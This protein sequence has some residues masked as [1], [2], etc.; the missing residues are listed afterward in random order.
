MKKKRWNNSRESKEKV[1]H[2][3]GTNSNEEQDD[4]VLYNIHS[5]VDQPIYVDAVDGN[6][7]QFQLDTGSSVS[8]M[9]C[10]DFTAVFGDS[11]PTLHPTNRRLGSYSGHKIEI[12][13][14]EQVQVDVGNNDSCELPLQWKA[15]VCHSWEGH[16]CS[17]SNFH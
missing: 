16:G 4:D 11:A 2:V 14:E 3:Q 1:H 6:Q 10:N 5:A 7:V 13:G 9:N 15:T 17:P 12:I 8:V